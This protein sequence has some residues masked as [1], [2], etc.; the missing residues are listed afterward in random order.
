M[1]NVTR[2][3]YA[4]GVG[5]YLQQ[6]GITNIPTAA[7]LKEACAYAAGALQAEPSE[8]AVPNDECIK[9]A[10]YIQDYDQRLRA[11]GKFASNARP[12]SIAGS[13]SDAYGDLV[14]QTYKLAME[15]AGGGLV[16]GTGS[17]VTPNTINNSPDAAAVL[18]AHRPEGYA[19]V[20]QGNANFKEPQAARI[21]IEQPHPLAPTGVGGAATNS[22]VEASKTATLNQLLRKL[23]ENPVISGEGE[24]PPNT[25]AGSQDGAAVLEAHRPEGYAVV[26]QGNANI[27][28]P[29]ASRI[30]TEQPHPL[31]PTG[32]GGA[33]SNSVVDA[34]KSASARWNEHFT[35]TAEAIG[36]HLPEA[37]PMDQK[38]AAVKQCMSLEPHEVGNYLQK[39]AHAYAPAPAQSVGSI[40][41]NLSNLNRR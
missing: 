18:E 41:G 35:R 24:A 10:A 37:M 17:T 7:L 1:S 4:R 39:V 14:A 8:S 15:S 26:G 30:G 23:A 28:E 40:L 38:V 36:P 9:V 2:Q 31:A 34:T 5:E 33:G 11:T 21:G 32:V 16:Q 12:A 6:A 27:G 13:I 20:G 19:H 25:V 29:Q 22:V 3:A